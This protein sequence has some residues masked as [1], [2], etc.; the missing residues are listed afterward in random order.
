[1]FARAL[2]FVLLLVICSPIIAQTIKGEVLDMETRKPVEGVNIENIYTSLDISTSPQGAFVIAAA[3]GQLLE[4]KKTGYKTV[5]VRIPK[6]YIPPFF[7]IIM[8]PGIPEIKDLY[9]TNRYDYKS[10]SIRFYE[11]YKHE[12]EFPRMSTIDVIAHPFD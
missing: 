8:R 7:R 3:G 2:L 11:L 1:M 10:D 9:A 5:R 6:G 4:F 12:L